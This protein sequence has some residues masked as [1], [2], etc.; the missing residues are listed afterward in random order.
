MSDN[1][2]NNNE[3]EINFNPEFVHSDFVEET[4]DKYRKIFAKKFEDYKDMNE[5][6]RKRFSGKTEDEIGI[7]PLFV[8]FPVVAQPNAIMTED[9]LMYRH[10]VEKYT[11]EVFGDP[12]HR[13][14]NLTIPKEVANKVV[15]FHN[16]WTNVTYAY[17][18]GDTRIMFISVRKRDHKFIDA[19]ECVIVIPRETISENDI[20]DNGLVLKFAADFLQNRDIDKI[21]KEYL[22]YAKDLNER[23]GKLGTV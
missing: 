3:V 12:E 21:A 8:K 7:I 4:A 5:I 23:I 6:K 14:L 18:G 19:W 15:S 10:I 2:T 22:A 20:T 1:Q 13:T 16:E 11:T 17:G 9:S